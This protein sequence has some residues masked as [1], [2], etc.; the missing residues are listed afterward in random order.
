MQPAI[1][2]VAPGMP[3]SDSALTA[4]NHEALSYT[5]PAATAEPASAVAPA[6]LT[7]YVFAHSK[8]SS[9]LGQRGV[10]ADLLIEDDAPPQAVVPPPPVKHAAQ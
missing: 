5:V 6:R 8:Y 3:V 4:Q 7:N 1:V 2:K 10:L 9:G